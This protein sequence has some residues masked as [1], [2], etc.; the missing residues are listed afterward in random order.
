MR[1]RVIAV[2][3]FAYAAILVVSV[4][5]CLLIIQSLAGREALAKA[6]QSLGFFINIAAFFLAI[7]LATSRKLHDRLGTGHGPLAFRALLSGSWPPI[8]AGVAILA[9]GV[10]IC[11]LAAVSWYYTGDISSPSALRLGLLMLVYFVFAA[12]FI[13]A[14]ATAGV[15]YGRR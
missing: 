10:D 13:T 7:S 14:G 12:V 4:V 15:R 9:V 3:G 8:A 11:M 2:F 5:S 1:I 6:L